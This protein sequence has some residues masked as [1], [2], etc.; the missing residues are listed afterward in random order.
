M[1]FFP[2]F[3]SIESATDV[4]HAVSLCH[5][6]VAPG[7]FRGADH[8]EGSQGNEFATGTEKV[9]ELMIKTFT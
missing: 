7:R 6:E 5:P 1:K 2:P 3:L 8:G 4:L 9:A